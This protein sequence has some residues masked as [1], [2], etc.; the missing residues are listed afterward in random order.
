MTIARVAL[1][2]LLAAPLPALS[3]EAETPEL[4]GIASVIDGDTIEIHAT[5]IRLDGI[6]APESAQLCRDG[7]DKVWRCGQRA[8]MALSERIDGRPVR[9]RQT[10]TD[11]YG[12]VVANCS[13]AGEGLNRWMVGQGWA[14]AYRHYSLAHVAAEDGARLAARGLWQGRFEMPWDWRAAQRGTL[15]AAAPLPLL[16][17]LAGQTQSCNPRKTCSAIGSCEEAHWYLQNCGWGS[18]LDRDGDGVPCESIC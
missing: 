15:P 2:L 9:C 16:L 7:R 3:S 5:R 6:D 8:A 4:S 13:V 18:K 14:V 11:R 12:R 10:G 17:Q 1:A